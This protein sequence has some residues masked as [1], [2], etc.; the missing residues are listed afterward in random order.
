VVREVLRGFI[1][2]AAR[3]RQGLSISFNFRS[4][5]K[6]L[7]ALSYRKR[8]Q[9]CAGKV[10]V[11]LGRRPSV[12]STLRKYII[13]STRV[14]EEKDYQLNDSKLPT[15]QNVIDTFTRVE[16]AQCFIIV[17]NG[18][19]TTVI[20]KDWKTAVLRSDDSCIVC[21]NHD[22]AEEDGATTI[23]EDHNGQNMAQGNIPVS[24]T[25]AGMEEILEESV[26]R[27]QWIEQKWTR[28]RNRYLKH[29]PGTEDNDAAVTLRQVQEW[30]TSEPV[31]AE[32]THFAVIM[33]PNTGDVVW[34]RRYPEPV[35]EYEDEDG[36]EE[37][38]EENRQ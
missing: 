4:N 32:C 22:Q 21:T 26:E 3:H 6:A 33:D 19:K 30:I 27:K 25:L 16:T 34:S 38:E 5:M 35:Y 18:T 11:L 17:C 14:A 9:Y 7:R 10:L 15:L 29:N 28:A 13:P 37:E 1:A 2:D 12:S 24:A 8:T 23:S 20:E 36:E 31:F